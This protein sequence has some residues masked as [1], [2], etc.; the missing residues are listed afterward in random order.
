MDRSILMR[1]LHYECICILNK[2][3]LQ[4]FIIDNESVSLFCENKS[5]INDH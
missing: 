5:L 1:V 2:H 4:Q 3:F